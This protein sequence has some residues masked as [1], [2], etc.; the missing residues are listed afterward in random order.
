ML[1]FMTGVMWFFLGFVF[2]AG[3]INIL[4]KISPKKEVFKIREEKECKD[5]IFIPYSYI[6]F[7]WKFLPRE[8]KFNSYHMESYDSLEK[9]EK[10]IEEYKCKQKSETITHSYK[11]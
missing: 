3:L 9:A 4:Q 5:S 8:S 7:E 6:E 2:I 11:G 1:E 10:A